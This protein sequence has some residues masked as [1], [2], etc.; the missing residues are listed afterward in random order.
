[1]RQY[2]KDEISFKKIKKLIETKRRSRQAPRKSNVEVA[3][4]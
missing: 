2:R 1:M 3:K 4:G